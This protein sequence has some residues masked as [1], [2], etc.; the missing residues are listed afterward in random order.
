MLCNSISQVIPNNLLT[1]IKLL[2]QN[3][4]LVDLLPMFSWYLG[5]DEIVAEVI[6]LNCGLHF[7]LCLHKRLFWT[8]KYD[9]QGFIIQLTLHIYYWKCYGLFARDRNFR[10]MSLISQVYK[11]FTLGEETEK[12]GKTISKWFDKNSFLWWLGGSKQSH[13]V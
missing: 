3:K 6:W 9:Y 11:V 12:K 13:R 4:I 7:F 10:S 5:T 1:Y 2:D 8:I